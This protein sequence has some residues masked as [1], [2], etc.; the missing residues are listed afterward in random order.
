MCFILVHL[1]YEGGGGPFL[2]GYIYIYIR[3]YHSICPL[4][5]Y[6]SIINVCQSCISSG[7]CAHSP[8]LDLSWNMIISYYVCVPCE[9][10]VWWASSP[11]LYLHIL[12]SYYISYMCTSWM[13]GVMV[14]FS[15]ATSCLM[16]ASRPS[17]F[18][19]ICPQS[20]C[21]YTYACMCVCVCVW[22]N[23]SYA[24][25]DILLHMCA[26]LIQP[27]MRHPLN[28]PRLLPYESHDSLILM[29]DT[30]HS[31]IRVTWRTR[32]Y[33]WHDSFV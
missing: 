7:G 33:V 20:I 29:C 3:L 31:P 18:L 14:S 11:L 15:L 13:Q 2:L 5:L 28:V 21:I 8:L 30:T 26:W 19:Q 32:S 12:S 10:R 1:V 22:F 4:S 6:D 27:Y 17:F 25:H 16:R 24:R 23:D 9:E